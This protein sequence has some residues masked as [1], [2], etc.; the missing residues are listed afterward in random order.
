MDVKEEGQ[1]TRRLPMGMVCA[2]AMGV[3]VAACAQN[4]NQNPSSDDECL[5][6]QRYRACD[7]R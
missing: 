4:Q 5:L 1:F 3:A 6:R 7:K 2:V